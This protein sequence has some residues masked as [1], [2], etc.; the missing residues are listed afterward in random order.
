[1]QGHPGFDTQRP[2]C[3]RVTTIAFRV[4]AGLADTRPGDHAIDEPT[5]EPENRTPRP[6]G[7][8]GRLTAHAALPLLAVLVLLAAGSTVLKL[9]PIPPQ[10][11][12]Y[13][14]L[15]LERPVG[16]ATGFQLSLLRSDPLLCQGVLELSAL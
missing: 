8:F 11:L 1:M 13:K 5:S 7:W 6:G 2:R 4:I 16:L 9:N 10:H 12:P 14:R 15:Y 3:S